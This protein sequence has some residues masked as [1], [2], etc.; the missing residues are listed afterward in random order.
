MG[1]RRN[2]VLENVG[3][4]KA[5]S[6]VVQGEIIRFDQ[7]KGYGFISPRSGGEDVFLHA[8]DLLDDKYL[9]R[10]GAIVEF[11][12]EPGERGPK[13]SLVHLVSAAPRSDF[14]TV[15]GSLGFGVAHRESA[16]RGSTGAVREVN[17]DSNESDE[18]L[19]DVLSAAEFNHEVTEVLL[20]AEPSLS[21]SQILAI[22]QAL[23]T[24]GSKF[25]WIGN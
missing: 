1:E 15:P 8:N 19:V 16:V 11:V 25:G 20:R 5:M 7:A 24:L 23:S 17:P 12:L 2:K 6:A 18:D 13:A 22:R 4:G 21:G 10:P 14:S 9:M 3:R